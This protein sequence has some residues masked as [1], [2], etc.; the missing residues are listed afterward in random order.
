VGNV[1][2][3]G[4][5]EIPQLSRLRSFSKTTVIRLYRGKGN[6]PYNEAAGDHVA[7]VGLHQS[8]QIGGCTEKEKK[9]T[10]TLRGF[11]R[12]V[13]PRFQGVCP[14]SEGW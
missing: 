11:F 2:R 12:G 7:V 4:G 5:G 9:E 8:H 6:G 1:H 3:V 13:D 14:V 10:W